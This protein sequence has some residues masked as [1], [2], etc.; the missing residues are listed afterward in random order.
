MIRVTVDD[1]DEFWR[2]IS[3]KKLTEKFAVKLD[4]PTNFPYGREIHLIDIA[5]VFGIFRWANE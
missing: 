4:E 3:E 2:E 5:G 1:L